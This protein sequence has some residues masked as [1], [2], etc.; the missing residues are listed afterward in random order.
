MRDRETER[1]REIYKQRRKTFKYIW[2]QQNKI[3]VR[4]M[5]DADD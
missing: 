2:R 1:E 4:I 3:P 5:T